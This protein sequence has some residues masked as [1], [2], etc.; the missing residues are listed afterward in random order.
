MFYLRK[1][2][3][4][5]VFLNGRHFS[6][7]VRVLILHCCCDTWN[8]TEN[9]HEFSHSTQKCFYFKT[10]SLGVWDISYLTI[11]KQVTMA[12]PERADMRHSNL[13][14]RGWFNF[15][16]CAPEEI[17]ILLFEIS[18]S[19]WW[20]FIYSIIGLFCGHTTSAPL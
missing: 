5:S 19:F 16:E 3:S 4:F 13:I 10:V 2:F 18:V 14:S 15:L 8:N 12:T 9:M 1:F 17:T 20:W 6:L 11:S 7:Q